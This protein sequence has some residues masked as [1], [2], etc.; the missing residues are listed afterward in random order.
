[1]IKYLK[2]T[3]LKNQTVLVRVDV[4]E[5]LEGSA[6][7]DDF[8]V[9][10]IVPTIELLRK[11]GCNII[12]AGHL[13]RPE[14]QWDKHLS[15]RPIGQRLAELL[16]LKFVET[17]RAMPNYPVNHLVFYTG[18][19]T[20][21][22]NR[23]LLKELEPGNV[24]LLENLRFYRGEDD[25]SA[26]LAKQLAS[27]ADAYVNEAFAVSHRKDASIAAITKYLPSYGGM[28]L[29][30][31]VKNLDYVLKRPRS[32]FVVMVGGIKISDKEKTLQ[33]LGKRAD[34]IL[35]GGGL[36]NILLQAQG[37]EIG[38]SVVEPDS[39]HLAVQLWHNFKDKLMLPK[40][41][42]VADTALSKSSIRA[43]PIYDVRQNEQILDLGPQTILEYA[44]IL[45][46]AKTLVWNGP[47]GRFEHKPFHMGTAALARVVG[48]VAKGR[49]FAV[50]GGGETVD[51][52]R[53]AHQQDYIDH[54]STGGGA[55]LSYLAGNKLPGLEALK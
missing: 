24:V 21:A 51:A 52:V 45:K 33:N 41:A 55:M 49:C 16:E 19:I 30:R 32:P 54:L 3:S 27:L 8:R 12:L 4:N 36:A 31:E 37:V 5:P 28:L 44:R 43:I 7:A 1:M 38:Q 11:Q 26:F 15:L 25:N 14:G 20:V 10:A 34:K 40:D 35:L 18:D 42:V 22:R 53:L 47:L 13:G 17:S 39:Q 23:S 29:E 9:R 50:V 6:L 48:G 2:S 46:T